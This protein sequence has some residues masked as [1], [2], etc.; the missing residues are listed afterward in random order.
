MRF[1]LLL[2]LS[3]SIIYF[4]LSIA[5]PQVFQPSSG[6]LETFISRNSINLYASQG[7]TAV[8]GF[9]PQLSDKYNA[10]LAQAENKQ[11]GAT[12]GSTPGYSF[13]DTAFLAV[14][15][16]SMI[17]GLN[18][19]AIFYVLELPWFIT[20][21]LAPV[22]ILMYWFGIFQFVRNGFVAN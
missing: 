7:S 17:T 15:F 13:L 18:V 8:E 11:S 22:I 9:Q 21:L 6:I 5:N 12:S 2:V 20:W 4:A 1:I 19:I 3:L 10:A 16:V 14:N